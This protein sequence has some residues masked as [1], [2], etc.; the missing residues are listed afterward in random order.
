MTP[1]Q[2]TQKGYA[3]MTRPYNLPSEQWMLDNVMADM[4]RG[5]LDAII[6]DDEVWRKPSAD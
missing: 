2:A 3:A 4:A 5:H 6:V 1:E